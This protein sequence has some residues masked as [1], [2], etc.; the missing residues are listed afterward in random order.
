MNKK[1]NNY[2]HLASTP[3]SGQIME[4]EA[5]IT[6]TSLQRRLKARRLIEIEWNNKFLNK[7]INQKP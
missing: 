3:N 7:P 6:T 5:A 1:V 2:N 4:V